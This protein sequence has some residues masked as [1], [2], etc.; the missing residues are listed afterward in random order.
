MKKSGQRTAGLCLT[1]LFFLLP[2][3]FGTL[4]LMPEQPP[5]FPTDLL[6]LAVISWPVYFV[7]IAGALLLIAAVLLF[8]APSR[9]TPGFL[10]ALFWGALIP[11]A[12]LP[13]LINAVNADY[14]AI[15]IAHWWGIGAFILSAWWIFSA[16][17]VW[18][19]YALN[20]LAAGVLITGIDGWRQHIWGFDE[21]VELIRKQREAGVEISH[22]MEI[23]IL[24]ARV[25]SSLGSCNTF[26]GF[27]LLTAPAA[28]FLVREWGK[29]FEPVKLSRLLFSLVALILLVPPFFMTRSRGAWL[30]ACLTGGIW[31]FTRPRISWKYKA[32]LL[33]LA[34][35]CAAGA[36][37][38]IARSDRGFLSGS[39]RLDYLR[40]TAIMC[41]EKPLT[42]WGWGEFF[43][44]HMKIKLSTSDESARSPHNMAASFAAHAGIPAGLVVLLAVGVLLF[45]LFRTPSEDPLY[46]AARWGAAA[47]L[48]HSCM[49]LNDSIPASMILCA[50]IPLAIMPEKKSLPEGEGLP[51]ASSRL[52][53][54]LAALLVAGFAFYT[55]FNWLRGEAAFERLELSMRPRGVPENF[56]PADTSQIMELLR[57][58][59][60]LRPSSPYPS[61]LVGDYLMSRG[62]L[63]GAKTLFERSFSFAPGRPAIHRRLASVAALQGDRELAKKHLSHARSLFPADPKN[64][65]ERFFEELERSRKRFSL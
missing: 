38:A 23:R 13:G 45:E 36:A 1:F 11:L 14:A 49:E 62:D 26:A 51:S 42:G 18:K 56:T 53:F 55:S 24:D 60:S 65:E 63:E 34:L 21:M 50:A 22:I 47:F 32:L 58:V 46:R 25:F 41:G 10:T 19:K 3:K 52:A 17:P 48:L 4:G 43:H 9:R 44:R 30:C 5:M 35:L 12:S 29:R 31:F 20:A 28:F 15:T 33:A 57:H 39:E 16:D 61:E 6:T 7:G 27:L 2:L 37:V 59:D 8:P 40:T 54:T 64:G